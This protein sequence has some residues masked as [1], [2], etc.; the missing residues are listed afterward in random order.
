LTRL[1]IS[2]CIERADGA[3]EVDILA[4]LEASSSRRPLTAATRIFRR[5]CVLFTIV[6]LSIQLSPFVPWYAR[7]LAGPWNDP[8]GDILIVL[9]SEEQSDGII[10][11]ISY[12]RAV[13]A[14]RAWNEGT[15]RAVVVSGGYMPGNRLSLA[16]VIGQFLEAYGIPK[17]DIFLEEHST[18]TRENALFTEKL[19]GSWPGKKVLLTDDF[20]TFRAVRAFRA[21]G[22]PVSPRPFPYILKHHDYI[23]RVPDA[24]ILCV[25][26]AKIAWYRERGWIHLF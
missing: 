15:F 10:G 13:Y 25:E 26:T 18:N 12:W 19:I 14:V 8:S 17:Q 7:F 24:W 3:C 16:A 9:G 6:I 21:A 2:D 4:I 23:D 1:R 22:L 11:P 20:N 5:A